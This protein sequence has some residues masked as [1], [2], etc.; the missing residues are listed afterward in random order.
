[1]STKPFNPFAMAQSQ[2]DRA[3]EQLGLDSAIREFLREP[4]R[5]V[6]FSIPLRMDDG[7]V[8]IYRGFRVLHND[9]RGPGKGG[10]RF[11]P[12]GTLDVIRALAMW[13]TWKTAVVDIPLGGSAGGV[14]VDPHNLSPA[15]LEQLC[16]R[17]MRFAARDLGPD[18]DV[19][20]P[21]IMAGPQQMLWML[22]EYE[23]IIGRHALGA[24]TGK[25]VGMG[26]SLGRKE[27]QG[28]GAVICVREAL[29]EIGIKPSNAL[30]SV[31]GF[32]NV[33][34]HAAKLCA[35]LGVKVLAVAALDR[36]ER[37]PFTVRREDGVRVEELLEITDGFGSIDREEAARLGYEVLP[38]NAWLEQDVDVLVPAALENQITAEN[39]GAVSQRVRVVAEGANGPTR[40]EA[41]QAL[42]GRGI[43]VIPD[44]LSG[45][46]GVTCSYFEQVQSNMNYFWERD[47]VLG[48]LDVKMTSAYIAVSDLARKRSLPM[49]D[50]AYIIAVSRVAGVC[51]ARGWL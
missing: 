12:A 39:V 20:E 31:Q 36:R 46:G 42:A 14:V 30:A 24:L 28:F 37:T 19:P 26:G 1:M 44:L 51:R 29:K 15:E 16:R 45:A 27:A 41:E 47:E 3:A 50:A 2:Y 11:H 32:G 49:R 9:A 22:D 10:L 5:E 25:P 7:G 40:P 4:M 18:V 35:D 8:H 6:V 43:K 33:G 38:G 17:F 21:D 13:M 48:K 23:A 34:Q